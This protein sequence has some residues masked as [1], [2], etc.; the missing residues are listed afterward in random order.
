MSCSAIV[1]CGG[2][3]S[4]A[5]GRDKGLLSREGRTLVECVLARIAPQVDDVVISA[6]RNR[7]RYET[8]GFKVTGDRVPGYQGPLAGLDAALP[9]CAHDHI[10]FVACDMPA[11]PNDLA[12]RMLPPLEK[13]DLCYAWDGQREQYLVGAMHRRL[14]SSLS[15]FIASGER[16]VRAW[17]AE[18]DTA[19]VDYSD[20]PEAFAN[21]NRPLN[22]E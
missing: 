13:H 5:G 7:K 9:F 3:G 2:R 4:R 8:F 6:N 20:R 10:L 18:L 16:A 21:I 17:Y 22:P 14:A 15:R 12:E 19:T 1:L 11:L